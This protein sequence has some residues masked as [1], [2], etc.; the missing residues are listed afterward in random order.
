MR[1]ADECAGDFFGFDEPLERE[2]TFQHGAARSG[3]LTMKTILT[4]T[5]LLS[6]SLAVLADHW[7]M[8]RG[9]NGDGTCTESNLPETWSAGENVAWKVKLPDRGNST[10]VIRGEKLFLTQAIEKEG[11]RL[12]LCFD[13]KPA[14]SS[15]TRARSTARRNSPMPRTLTAPPHRRPMASG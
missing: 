14:S 13:K 11:K 4:L 15:G 7:P 3:S 6:T 8:W 2:M 10:P 5:A 12:L 1:E 9:A